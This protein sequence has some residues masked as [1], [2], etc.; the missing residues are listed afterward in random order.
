MSKFY[1]ITHPDEP[2]SP[3]VLDEWNGLKPGMTVRYIGDIPLPYHL[4]VCELIEFPGD[5]F[6]SG[7]VT[8]ILNDG[9]WELDASNLREVKTND[10]AWD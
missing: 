9:D 3:V 2:G 5:G 1:D 10:D 6:E 8:A 4:V 7:W